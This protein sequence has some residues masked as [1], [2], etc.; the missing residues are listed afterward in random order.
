[1]PVQCALND[2]FVGM[3][4]DFPA[5][6]QKAVEDCLASLTNRG[7]EGRTHDIGSLFAQTERLASAL[8]K[9]LTTMANRV[10]SKQPA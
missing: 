1:M 3:A 6:T 4:F 10:A 2:P 9:L 7:F 8:N 5:K